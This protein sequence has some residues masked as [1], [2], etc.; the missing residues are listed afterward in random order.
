MS[1]STAQMI[2]GVV[3]ALGTLWTIP[4]L[5]HLVPIQEYP[6]TRWW[7][8]PWFMTALFLP[9]LLVPIGAYVAGRIWQAIN[10]RR[11]K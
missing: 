2:G 3:G 5:F 6:D 8:F 1:N 10:T 4:F 11:T 9:T 7:D